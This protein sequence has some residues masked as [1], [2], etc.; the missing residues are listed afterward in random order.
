MQERNSAE[1]NLRIGEEGS[2]YWKSTVKVDRWTR[3][4]IECSAVGGNAS[5]M[6]AA[7]A[8]KLRDIPMGTSDN[9]DAA[10]QRSTWTDETLPIHFPLIDYGYLEGRAANFDVPVGR[11]R[12]ACRLWRFMERGFHSIGFSLV[13]KGRFAKLAPKLIMPSVADNIEGDQQTK[14]GYAAEVTGQDQSFQTT[15]DTGVDVF[16]PDFDTIVSDPSGSFS[17]ATERYTMPLQFNLQPL[18]T[19]DIEQTTPG[20][21][22][23]ALYLFVRDGGTALLSQTIL[24]PTSFDGTT[25]YYTLDNFELPVMGLNAGT[26]VY[27][28]LYA[29][30]TGDSAGATIT[31]SRP[32]VRWQPVFIP[33]QGG[34]TI[35]INTTAPDWTLAKCVQ[36]LSALFNVKFV[37]NDI[38]GQVEAWHYDDFLKATDRGVDWR[39]KEDH[40]EAPVKQAPIYPVRYE[41]RFAED[42]KDRDLLDVN[43]DLSGPGLGN[44]DL[45][46]GGYLDPLRV[47]VDW[48]P[49]AMGTGLAGNVFIPVMRE[50]NATYQ[51]DSL[52]REERIL[53]ADLTTPNNWRHDSTSM[54]VQPKVFFVWPGEQRWSASFQDEFWYGTT[55]PGTVTQ[56]HREFLRRATESYTLRI[57]IRL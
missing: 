32:R 23:A 44:K 1:H 51:V 50:L 29:Y 2:T 3:D 9:I 39:G 45:E 27:I 54:N 47:K 34:I 36:N 55:A 35:D 48:A 24:Q 49:T 20:S 30:G 10:Y 37:T 53:I 21:T 13:A 26:A 19:M 42:D 5:W 11:L 46:T 25:A 4:A 22:F 31:V 33:Y 56:Y 17:L 6:E 15:G 28:E 40:N 52:K 41:F 18:V 12:P 7:K 43:E 16:T 14:D 38:T 57:A 8:K